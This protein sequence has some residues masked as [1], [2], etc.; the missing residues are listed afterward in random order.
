[1]ESGGFGGLQG[2]IGATVRGVGRVEAWSIKAG[3]SVSGGGYGGGRA[4]RRR[5]GV[6]EGDSRAGR[7]GVSGGER[8]MAGAE[9]S[10]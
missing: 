8:S 10:G 9:G 6:G 2:V 5:L 3:P 1:M 7:T 4:S